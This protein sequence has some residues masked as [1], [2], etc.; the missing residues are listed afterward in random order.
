MA[1][2]VPRSALKRAGEAL[3]HVLAFEP[4]V[5]RGRDEARRQQAHDGEGG[6]GLARAGLAHHAQDLA[7]AHGQR[8]V[9]HRVGAV[10]PGRQAHRQAAD[11]QDGL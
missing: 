5:A 4:H 1:M 3:Q 11:G 6:D 2:R 10:G 7:P 9:L 8:H